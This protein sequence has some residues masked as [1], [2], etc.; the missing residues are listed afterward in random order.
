[1]SYIYICHIYI[2]I[3]IYMSNIYV[4]MSNIYIYMSNICI[5]YIYISYLHLPHCIPTV[6]L[7]DPPAI[8]QHGPRPDD[9]HS[10]GKWPIEIDVS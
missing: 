10:H 3:I 4:Y 8:S 2:Y 9:A 6:S 1:M 7:Q 5:I